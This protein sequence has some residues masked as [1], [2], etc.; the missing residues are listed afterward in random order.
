MAGAAGP[1]VCQQAALDFLKDYKKV[2]IAV[3]SDGTVVGD[4]TK[5]VDKANHFLSD[6]AAQHSPWSSVELPGQGSGTLG[7]MCLGPASAGETPVRFLFGFSSEL[8]REALSVPKPW[9]WDLERPSKGRRLDDVRVF[10]RELECM[11]AAHGKIKKKYGMEDERDA[12]FTAV[13]V[14]SQALK[15]RWLHGSSAAPALLPRPGLRRLAAKPFAVTWRSRIRG[16]MAIRLRSSFAT[17]AVLVLTALF[18]CRSWN[19]LD[20]VNGPNSRA[21]NQLMRRHLAMEIDIDDAVLRMA[22]AMSDEEEARVARIEWC[23]SA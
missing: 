19:L 8:P 13:D 11:A 22:M 12:L 5:I 2:P 17:R 16:A 7:V 23:S 18:A 20:F 4:S 21:T 6:E 10:S 15:S 1:V 9:V 14:P 3:F